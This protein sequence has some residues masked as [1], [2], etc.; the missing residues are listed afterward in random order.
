MEPRIFQYFKK[1][2]GSGEQLITSRI[3]H[4]VDGNWILQENEEARTV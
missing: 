4:R 1:T 3:R 2:T